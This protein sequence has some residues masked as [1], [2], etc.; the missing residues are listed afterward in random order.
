MNGILK[1]GRKTAHEEWND[2]Y[3]TALDIWT[4][5]AKGNERD[6]WAEATKELINQYGHGY[7]MNYDSSI[8]VTRGMDNLSSNLDNDNIFSM[9]PI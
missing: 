2:P 3:T 9:V 4:Q 6:D 5:Y 8:T 1:Q 7:V